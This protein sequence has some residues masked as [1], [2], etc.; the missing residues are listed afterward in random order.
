[1]EKMQFVSRLKLVREK[2]GLTQKEAA[3]KL[4]IPYT[5]YNHYETGR[6]QPDIETIIQI[7]KFFGITS[8]YLLGCEDTTKKETSIKPLQIEI[9]E[10]DL[11]L[12]QQLKKLPADKREIVDT[13]IKISNKTNEQAASGK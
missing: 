11:A 2:A 10:E 1:M 13:V 12:L 6:N 3:S 4:N 5:K 7:A 8:D 9:S